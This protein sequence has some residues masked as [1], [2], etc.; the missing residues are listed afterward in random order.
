MAGLILQQSAS[1]RAEMRVDMRDMNGRL[2]AL[3]QR[4]GCV[5]GLLEGLGLSGKISQS[6]AAESLDDEAGPAGQS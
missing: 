2:G 3:E 6:R 5:Q 4:M 1:L